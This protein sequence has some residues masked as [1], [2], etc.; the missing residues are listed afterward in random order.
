[1]EKIYQCY[2]VGDRTENGVWKEH[3]YV[4]FTDAKEANQF[5]SRAY[6]KKFVSLSGIKGTKAKWMETL[7]FGDVT[8]LQGGQS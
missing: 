8:V 6:P 5:I 3:I 1:M 7:K 4:L 2:L